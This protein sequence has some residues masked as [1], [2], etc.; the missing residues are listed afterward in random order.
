MRISIDCNR[1]LDLCSAPTLILD[2][3]S[4]SGNV[5]LQSFE[6]VN[7]RWVHLT[8]QHPATLHETVSDRYEIA[9]ENRVG[10]NLAEEIVSSASDRSSLARSISNLRNWNR[11]LVPLFEDFQDYLTVVLLGSDFL[12]L[13]SLLRRIERNHFV[14]HIDAVDPKLQ[15]VLEKFRCMSDV[16]VELNSVDLLVTTNPNSLAPISKETSHALRKHTS[17]PRTPLPCN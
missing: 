17:P 9:R 3:G 15:S 10:R 5:V 12:F 13:P 1:T 14:V 2:S 11:S 7:L 8:V 4:W 16:Q 6:G